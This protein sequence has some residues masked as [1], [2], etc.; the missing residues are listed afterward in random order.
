MIKLVASDVDGTILKYSE[1]SLK[2]SV[3][4]MVERLHE[5]GILFVAAS[6]R[7]LCELKHLFLPVAD[8]MGFICNDGALT[9]IGDEIIEI[10]PIKKDGAKDLIDDIY[11]YRQCEFL[12][13][14]K[15]KA[16]IKPK[17]STYKEF[18]R[19]VLYGNEVCIEDVKDIPE[20]YLKIA[21]YNE[22]GIEN[23]EKYFLDKYAE[24]YEVAY[25]ANNWI[26]FN[27]LG[28]SKATGIKKLMEHLSINSCECMAF[29][30][31]FNDI[32]MFESV[33][34]SFAMETAKDEVKNHCKFVCKSVEETV[35]KV[36]L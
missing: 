31:S 32:S 1:L 26:E 25:A 23:V 30:D 35:R 33:E 24:R 14:C 29:G 8:K 15:D 17:T 6:G 21:V 16:Y 4:D 13:Y 5:K 28:V 27:A 10:N 12:V 22:A 36:L 34:H 20:D 18:A 19:G 2:K 3:F 7:P 9:L 11:S